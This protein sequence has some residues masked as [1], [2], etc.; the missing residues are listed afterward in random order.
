MERLLLLCHNDFLL[1]MACQG[2]FRIYLC[3][4]TYEL[5]LFHWGT[6]GFGLFAANLDTLLRALKEQFDKFNEY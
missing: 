4:V 6:P 2:R 5:I 1:G 3:A